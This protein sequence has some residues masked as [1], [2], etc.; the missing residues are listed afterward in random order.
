MIGILS[1]CGK[2]DFL[3]F[4]VKVVEPSLAL[5]RRKTEELGRPV[6]QHVF[7]FDLKNFS[8]AA[9]THTATIDLLRKLIAIYEGMKVTFLSDKS[10]LCAAGNY[11]ETL[12][13]AY[14]INA[15]TVFQLIF[16]VVQSS[17]QQKTLKKIKV[18][19]SGNWAEVGNPS[20]A[21]GKV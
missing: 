2:D 4:T 7:I 9:A 20:R 17:V 6:T 5:M 15:S 13:A 10:R 21:E 19:G 16:R 11:P 12:K 14:V 18:F 1:C 3:K 8:L